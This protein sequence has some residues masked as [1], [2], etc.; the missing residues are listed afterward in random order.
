MT[1]PEQGQERPL[2]RFGRSDLP[3]KRQGWWR[4]IIPGQK[5]RWSGAGLFL[6]AVLLALLVLSI[7]FAPNLLVKQRAAL[8]Q[9]TGNDRVQAEIALVQ[10]RNSVRTTLVQALGGAI[11][12]LTLVIGLGQLQVARQGQLVDRF[13]KT[14]DQLGAEAVDVRLGAIFALQQIAERPEYTRPVA[15]ILLAY[16]K[17]HSRNQTEGNKSASPHDPVVSDP[18]GQKAD[19]ARWRRTGLRALLRRLLGGPRLHVPRVIPGAASD[20][21]RVRLQPDLQAALRI[22]VADGLWADAMP[23]RPLDLSFIDVRY[24]DLPN[25][26]LAGFVL[27]GAVLDGSNLRGAR[28]MS[29]DLRRVSLKGADLTSADLTGADLTDAIATA[30][31]TDAIPRK[32]TFDDARLENALLIRANLSGATLIR[33]HLEYTDATNADLSNA[34]LNAAHLDHAVLVGTDLKGAS[35]V[36]ATMRYIGLS[37]KTNLVGAEITDVEMDEGTTAT[38]KKLFPHLQA[39]LLLSALGCAFCGPSG[40]DSQEL[41][42]VIAETWTIGELL[43][44]WI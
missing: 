35:L 9:L 30:D 40:V 28:M 25:V 22:L 11:V 24:A 44:A 14:I 39:K 41:C 17:T 7:F 33:T 38:V 6:A 32:T 26:N 3:A 42:G 4:I 43:R 20:I 31:L 34:T 23:G 36:G 18:T 15:E 13:T 8:N 21:G 19:A 37:D 16:L 10:A 2:D 1:S 5:L 29:A 12:L 27:L